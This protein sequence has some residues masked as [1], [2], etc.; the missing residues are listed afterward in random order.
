MSKCTPVVLAVAFV[1]GLF[2]I[3]A[4]AEEITWVGTGYMST[5]N[6]V[7]D[8][9]SPSVQAGEILIEFNNIDYTAYCVDLDH[10][11]KNECTATIN[12]VE[13]ITHGLAAAYL[14]DN[15]A[16]G[17]ASNA[18]AAGLQVA[19]WEVV[20]DWDKSSFDLSGGDFRLTGP[21][22]VASYAGAFLAAL[23][24]DLSNY[25]TSSFVLESGPC[26]RSQHLIVPEPATMG[27]VAATIPLGL[28]RRRR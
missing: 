5:V 26:P 22:A 2:T 17:V 10:W 24:A 21:S 20:E 16:G 28:I 7:N 25:V 3:Q 19:I 23:P 9:N 27:L 6:L 18:E 11:M 12:T 15:F 14:Y 1:A 13:A 8:G 4:Q